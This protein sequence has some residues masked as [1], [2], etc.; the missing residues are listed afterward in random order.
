MDNWLGG[1]DSADEACTKFN[2]A[3]EVLSLAGM[4]LEKREK[5]ATP[6]IHSPLQG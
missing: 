2:E 1:A 3:C 6:L 4:P 5:C